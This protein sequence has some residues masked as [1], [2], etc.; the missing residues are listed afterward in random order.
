MEKKKHFYTYISLFFNSLIVTRLARVLSKNCFVERVSL[1][2][3]TK[4]ERRKLAFGYTKRCTQMQLDAWR[5][6]LTDARRVQGPRK[7]KGRRRV[8][9]CSRNTR[10]YTLLVLDPLTYRDSQSADMQLP[11]NFCSLT[12]AEFPRSIERYRDTVIVDYCIWNVD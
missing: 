2:M 1:W 3:I 4:S 12:G 5:C 11:G 9:I 10:A 7:L 6:D 8:N